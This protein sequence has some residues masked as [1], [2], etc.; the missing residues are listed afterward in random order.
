M[1]IYRDRKWRFRDS[2]TCSYS[3]LYKVPLNSI[4]AINAVRDRLSFYTTATL[5]KKTQSGTSAA[6]LCGIA[7]TRHIT[8]R[9]WLSFPTRGCE[10]VGAKALSGVFGSGI[11]ESFRVTIFDAARCGNFLTPIPP[12]F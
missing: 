1:G 3:G 11:C 2:C 8:I 12:C 4:M 9:I 5:L 6:N 7:L 10:A